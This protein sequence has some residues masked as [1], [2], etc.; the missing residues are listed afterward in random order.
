MNEIKE[1]KCVTWL[2]EEL[3]KLYETTNATKAFVIPIKW[4]RD[5]SKGKLTQMSAFFVE[6]FSV[7]RLWFPAI[8]NGVKLFCLREKPSLHSRLNFLPFSRTASRKY[9]DRL[10]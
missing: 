7:S 9:V 5:D 1:F 10:Y 6:L 2:L 4:R 3:N 8:N